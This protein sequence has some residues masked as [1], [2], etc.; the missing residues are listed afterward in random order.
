MEEGLCEGGL[1]DSVAI[2][3]ATTCLQTLLGHTPLVRFSKG[4]RSC[5]SVY[6]FLIKALFTDQSD[7]RN[8]NG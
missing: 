1:A 4:D 3:A 5:R 6:F 7:V 8:F 2:A